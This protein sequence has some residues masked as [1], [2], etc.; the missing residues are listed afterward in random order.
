MNDIIRILCVQSKTSPER[1]MSLEHLQSGN[2]Q[3]VDAFNRH[4]IVRSKTVVAKLASG[5]AE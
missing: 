3:P 4:S 2:I 5:S 1:R